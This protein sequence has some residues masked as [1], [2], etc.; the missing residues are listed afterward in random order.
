MML[1]LRVRKSPGMVVAERGSDSVAL[2]VSL[3]SLCLSLSLSVSLPPSSFALVRPLFCSG[4]PQQLWGFLIFLLAILEERE[5]FA[6]L[7]LLTNVSS[8]APWGGTGSLPSL[9]VPE[10]QQWG[11]ACPPASERGSG[12]SEGK[13]GHCCHRKGPWGLGRYKHYLQQPSAS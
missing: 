8:R 7:I 13:C 9:W 11:G 6:F 5:G 3:S 12:G 2:A 1:S 10:Q 4:S